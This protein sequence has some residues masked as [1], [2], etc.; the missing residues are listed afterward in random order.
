LPVEP[1]GFVEAASLMLP[2]RLFES[3][4]EHSWRH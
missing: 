1:L 3:L 2:D 4:L